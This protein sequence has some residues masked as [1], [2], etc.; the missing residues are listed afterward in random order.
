MFWRGQ[1]ISPPEKGMAIRLMELE[2]VQWIYY[3]L[4]GKRGR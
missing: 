3:S 1:L 2:I 4:K